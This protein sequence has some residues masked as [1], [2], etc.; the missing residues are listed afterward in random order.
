[1]LPQIQHRIPGPRYVFAHVVSP[2][3]PLLFGRNGEPVA[4]SADELPEQW[5]NRPGYVDQVIFI[6]R[7]VLAAVDRILAEARTPPV[8]VL[9]GDHG[10][11][12]TSYDWLYGDE[13]PPPSGEEPGLDVILRERMGILNAYHLP[14]G[15]AGLYASISPVNS[16]RVILN[17][18]LG[19]SNRLLED[20]SFFSRYAHPYRWIDVTE[21]VS[22]PPASPAKAPTATK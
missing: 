12:A 10:S 8:I 4:P 18:Y 9:Q 16:F 20:R 7:S 17:R 6:N 5:R 13:G 22:T 3:T 21:R 19:E 2:E 11:A 14:G 15:P 1:M